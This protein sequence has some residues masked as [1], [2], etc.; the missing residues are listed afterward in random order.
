MEG[1]VGGG[2]L[3]PLSSF[4]RWCVGCWCSRALIPLPLAATA[5]LLH[6]FTPRKVRRFLPR[7]SAESKPVNLMSTHPKW[8]R[9]K[10]HHLLRAEVERQLVV[11]LHDAYRAL[12]AVVDEHER[13]GL[14]AVPPHLEVFGGADGLA[15]E[16][17]R[18]FLAPALFH[19]IARHDMTS[20]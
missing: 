17:G 13:P 15:A 19:H 9:E 16:R 20:T 12:H 5:T 2:V 3:F 1:D 4:R 10:T 11:A 6:T 18:G 7:S 8:A 14:L